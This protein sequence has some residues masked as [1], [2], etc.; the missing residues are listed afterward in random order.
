MRNKKL[1]E[2][3]TRYEQAKCVGKQYTLYTY[4]NNSACILHAFIVLSLIRR[5]F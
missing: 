3:I 2:Y 4:S 5:S 1:G